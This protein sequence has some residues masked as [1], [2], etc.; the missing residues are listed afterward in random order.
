MVLRS[1][2][3][4]RAAG[5]KPFK[6]QRTDT[7]PTVSYQPSA[8]VVPSPPN[9]YNQIPQRHHTHPVPNHAW[10]PY[11]GQ[12][13]PNPTLGNQSQSQNWQQQ[14][15]SQGLVAPHINQQWNRQVA[16]SPT[17]QYPPQQMTQFY[18]AATSTP[19]A[20]QFTANAAPSFPLPQYPPAQPVIPDR[21]PQ[22]RQQSGHFPQAPFPAHTPLQ[23]TAQDPA[24]TIDQTRSDQHGEPW[25]EELKVLDQS[26]EISLHSES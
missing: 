3:R 9:P 2:I 24:I 17:S 25:L 14:N 26:E 18:P 23:Q 22:I 5:Q 19:T 16:P 4:G 10:N 1:N 21:S 7:Y 11:T 8:G 12:P 15:W 20:R 6:R 13:L